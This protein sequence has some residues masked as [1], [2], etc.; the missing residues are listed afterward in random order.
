M[1]EIEN[2]VLDYLKIQQIE[3]EKIDIDPNFS[4]TQ[5]FC[6]KYKFEMNI[7]N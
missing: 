5:N 2:I 3:Y 7:I 1:N 6:N 4:D